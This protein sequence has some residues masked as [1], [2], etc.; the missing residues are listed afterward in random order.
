MLELATETLALLFLVVSAVVKWRQDPDRRAG[1]L[2]TL[3]D[4]AGRYTRFS[5][6]AYLFNLTTVTHGSAPNRLI[7]SYMLG[8]TT[9]ALFGAVDR[10]IQFAKQYEPVKLLMGLFRPVFNAQYRSRDDYPTIMAMGDGMFRLNLVVLMLPLLPI[11]V[12]GEY[13]FAMITAGK[14]TDAANLF[15]GFYLILVL[16]SFMMVLELLVKA[17]EHTRIFVVSNLVLSG[18][19]LAAW[20]FLDT[21]GLWALVVAVSVGQI[22]AILIVVQYLE[23]FRFPVRIRWGQVGK[24]CAAVAL[25]VLAGLGASFAGWH[26]LVAILLSYLLYTACILKWLPFTADEQDVFKQMFMKKLGKGAA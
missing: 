10:L 19:A 6:W 15:M 9:V 5:W 22:V 16:A 8:P 23:H 21:A 3:R 4:D 2:A 11:A 12:A 14:Y 20:P 1:S 13:V 7:V 17:V 25:A 18:S 24:I 26:P